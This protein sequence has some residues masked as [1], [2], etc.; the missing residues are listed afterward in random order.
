[1]TMM[2]TTMTTDSQVAGRRALR[3]ATGGSAAVAAA[4]LGVIAYAHF[5]AL[6]AFKLRALDLP[7]LPQD[8]EPLKILHISDIHFVPG[9]HKK[10][11]WIRQLAACQPDLVINTGDNLSHRKAVPEVLHALEPLLEFPGA[12]VLGSNDYYAPLMKNPLHYLKG[13]SRLDPRAQTLPTEQLTGTFEASGWMNLTNAHATRTINGLKVQLTGVDDPHI[14]RD[15]FT[16]FGEGPADLKLAVA[17]APVRRILE[18]FADASAQ[19]ILAGH[20]HGGQVCLP[21]ERALV[22]NCDLPTRYAKGLSWVRGAQGA[23]VPVHVSAGLGTSAKA[24]VRFNC[25]PE[26]TLIT[27]RPAPVN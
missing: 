19:L 22:T 10:Q 6:K 4:G 13:P 11:E 23:D 5:V 27:L 12:F 15:E 18:T 7:L 25:P 20:T 2:T 21:G 3:L 14:H 16:G 24:Q 8:T 9:Q 1:M 17:H 26:A